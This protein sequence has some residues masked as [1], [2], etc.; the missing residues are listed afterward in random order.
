MVHI[1]VIPE[2]GRPR[3]HDLEFEASLGYTARLCYSSVVELLPGKDET[4]VHES[5]L[6]KSIKQK[7][8]LISKTSE[9][10]LERW[11]RG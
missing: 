3:Q 5:P 2:L 10:G 11:L 9:E 8:T 6:P 4:L 1:P 7:Q